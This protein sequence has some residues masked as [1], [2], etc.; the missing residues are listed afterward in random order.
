MIKL[1]GV[2]KRYDGAA[3][4]AVDGVSLTV[5]EATTTV[6]IGPSG[7][8]K[9]TVLRMVNRLVEPTAG[10]IEVAGRAIDATDAVTLRRSIGYVIQQGGLFPHMTVG[11]NVATVPRLLDW[12]ANRIAARI[13]EMLTLVGL[14]PEEFRDRFPRALSGGQRQRVG[15]ARALAG[16]PPVLLM[17]EP[18]GA[19]DPIARE[20]LQNELLGILKR[21]KKTVLLVTHDIDEALK[22]ADQLAILDHGRLVQ[23]GA[24]DAVLLHPANALVA[25][26]VG[27]DRALK[28]LA[29]VA[30]SALAKPDGAAAD[31]PE[32]APEVSLR[33][34]LARMLETGSPALRVI[35]G[36]SV[37]LADIVARAR[38]R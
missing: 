37:T 26:L 24:P 34:A 10:R 27:A 32:I 14:A 25:G 19:I 13:D 36:G 12:P 7:C 35:G 21:I 17:D 8:G 18:F 28:G 1:D 30:V 4:P 29:L 16:D 5:P 9:T 20:R 6:L 33:E 23:H 22:L 15:V 3:R 11:E 31:Q 38:A 2:T